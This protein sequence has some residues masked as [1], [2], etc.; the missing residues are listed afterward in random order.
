MVISV[1]KWTLW[2]RSADPAGALEGHLAQ[3]LVAVE[4]D[5]AVHLLEE[6]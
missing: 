1:L 3:C 4:A 5:L 2:V 6:A